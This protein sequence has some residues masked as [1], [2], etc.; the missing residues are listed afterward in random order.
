MGDSL[1][2]KLL[3]AT[4]S[5]LDANFYRSVI[6]VC[7]HGPGG[8]LGLIIN[9]PVWAA[10]VAEHLAMW[11][12][13]TSYPRVL[14]A[15]GPVE[16]SSALALGRAA[17]QPASDSFAPVAHGAGLVSL[18]REPAELGFEFTDLRVFT[19]Y[20]GWGEGQLEEEIKQESWFVVNSEPGDLFGG[21]PEFLWRTVLRRQPGALAMFAYFPE[22]PRAN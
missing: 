9:R 19:G 7:E 20:A 12:P 15:G 1:A 16:P 4:P 5:L 17:G 22:D 13:Q 6:F 2:G 3:V 8:A 14:F 21:E 18:S 11:E 10:D